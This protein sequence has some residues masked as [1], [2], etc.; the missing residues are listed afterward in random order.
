MSKFPWP[1][2]DQPAEMGTQVNVITIAPHSLPCTYPSPASPGSCLRVVHLQ[3]YLCN[4]P[5]H[6]HTL[7]KVWRGPGTV[8][9]PWPVVG[10]EDW[11]VQHVRKEPLPSRAWASQQA[12]LF[13]QL[14]NVGNADL[15]TLP[16]WRP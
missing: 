6:S 4:S 15:A 2:S 10:W 9:L 8:P 3:I 1:V 16:L 5:H 12:P 11:G 14:P 13:P 7:R